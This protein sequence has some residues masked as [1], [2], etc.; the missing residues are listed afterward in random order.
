MGAELDPAL[1]ESVKKKESPRFASVRRGFDPAQVNEFLSAIAS[2]VEALEK[3][4]HELQVTGDVPPE[5]ADTEEVSPSSPAGDASDEGDASDGSTTRIARLAEV[6][7]REVERMLAEAKAEAV[8]IVSDAKRDADRLA[9][10][11]KGEAKRSVDEAQAFLNKV[12]EDAGRMVSDLAGRRRQMLEE[13]RTMQ[14]RLVS[15]AK[16]LDELVNPEA[17]S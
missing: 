10:E 8:T 12:E 9:R 1:L 5:G 3:E 16:E 2:R 17:G 6:G 15:V 14:E 4:L 11:A 7:V 13:F